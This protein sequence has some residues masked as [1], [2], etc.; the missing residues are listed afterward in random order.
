MVPAAAPASSPGEL[1]ARL[2]GV[3]DGALH[4]VAE[5]EFLGE[6]HRGE[7]RR[8]RVVTRAEE[9]HE[10]ARVI[11]DERLLDVGAESE[12]FAEVGGAAGVGHGGGDLALKAE[13]RNARRT[14]E[15]PIGRPCPTVRETLLFNDA[16][17]APVL[18]P[19]VP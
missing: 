6:P 19:R 17:Q 16:A 5:P 7:P 12:A 3:V 1:A 11:G 18:A 14:A 2:V 15:V 8:E 10:L 4:A 9:V 13:R